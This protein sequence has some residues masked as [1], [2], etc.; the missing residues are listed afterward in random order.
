[1]RNLWIVVVVLI[2][3]LWLPMAARSAEEADPPAD[4]AAVAKCLKAEVNPVTGHATCLDPVGAP[5]EPVPR[6]SFQ[7][8]CKPRAHDDDPWTIYEHGSKCQD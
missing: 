4:K 2:P 8:P 6:S 1:V 7:Q 3:V 5:V